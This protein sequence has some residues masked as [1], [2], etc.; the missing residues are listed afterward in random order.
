MPAQPPTSASDDLP[1]G[2]LLVEEYGALAVA[3]SSALRKFAPLHGI[4]V[5]H[6]FAEAETAA[7]RM[8][9]ELYVI[10]LDP[11]P[12][13]EI[14]FFRNLQKQYPDARVLV[15]AAGTSRKLQAQRGTTGALQF[16]EKPFDLA[17]F[18]AAV[19]ALVGPWTE[20]EGSVRGTVRDLSIFDLMQLKCLTGCTAVVHLERGDGRKGEIHFKRGQILHAATR[21]STGLPAL[22]EIVSWPE[23]DLS[24]TALPAEN[25]RSIDLPWPELLLQVFRKLPPRPVVKPSGETPAPRP[26]V[27]KTGK[28]ILVIDDTEMLLIFVADVL[29]TADH[30][31]QV[32]TAATGREGAELARSAHPDLVLLDY[33]LTDTTGDQVCRAL[34]EDE[35]TARIPVLMMSGH[36]TELARTAEDYENVVAALPKPFLSGAL[37]NAVEKALASGPRPKNQPKPTATAPAPVSVMP[38]PEGPAPP[39][40]NGHGRS[41]EGPAANAPPPSISSVIGIVEAPAL[42]V[43][44]P[45]IVEPPAAAPL[46]VAAAPS[47]AFPPEP[48]S[49]VATRSEVAARFAK[50]AELNVTFA[51]EVVGLQLTPLLRIDFV[52]LQPVDDVVSVQMSAELTGFPLGM[53]FRLGPFQLGGNGQIETVRLIPTGQAVPPQATDPSFAVG[54]ANFQGENA[55]G[56]LELTAASEPS[57][58]VQLTATF[59][60]ERVELSNTFELGALFLCARGTRVLLRNATGEGTPFELQEVELDE[61]GELRRF[62]ARSLA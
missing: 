22:E 3:I 17:E 27:A 16:I 18:G 7:A 50:R 62:L 19:Q 26:P 10:D 48:V 39:L 40:R 44:A 61:A 15:I 60:L 59:E 54:E 32:V 21:L 25:P 47:P 9:P 49:P 36:L 53:G 11:P 28:K 14:R 30:S 51:L 38:P 57:M 58:R 37:I 45:E 56:N 52:R 5:A 8:R 33:S 43:I 29:A 6:N 13:G 35:T 46:P 55:A 31:F 41:E 12:S 23:S 24:E 34:L 2:I 20:S 1:R 4:E 42:K